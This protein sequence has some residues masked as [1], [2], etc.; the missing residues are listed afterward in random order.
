[1]FEMPEPKES[2][3]EGS[4]SSKPLVLAAVSLDGFVNF[5]HV[6]EARCVLNPSLPSAPHV[7]AAIRSTAYPH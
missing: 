2:T 7:R 4:S 3:D 1:M 6:V 5:A